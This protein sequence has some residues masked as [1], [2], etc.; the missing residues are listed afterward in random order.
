VGRL[1]GGALG[2]Q[3]VVVAVTIGIAESGSAETGFVVGSILAAVLAIVTVP[4]AIVARRLR[5]PSVPPA[6]MA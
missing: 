5:I 1:I 6:P 4:L 3:L 2:S